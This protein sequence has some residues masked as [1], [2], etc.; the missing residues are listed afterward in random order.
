MKRKVR[1][2]KTL[3]V[4]LL[5]VALVLCA[6]R[7]WYVNATAYSFETQEYGIGEWIPLNGDFFYS[8]EENT[9]GYSVRVREA[10][11]VRYEDFMQ[12][13]GKPV[14]YLAENTQHDVVLLTV[15]FKNENN[16]DGGVFIRD[17]NLLNEAQ[18]AYFNKSEIYMKI[19]NPDLNSKADGIS[20][21]PGTEA[22]L[23]MVYP[24]SGRADGVTYLEEQAGKEQ[25]V[26]YLNVSLYPVKKCVHTG[27]TRWGFAHAA[28]INEEDR[29]KRFQM[30]FVLFFVLQNHFFTICAASRAS[31]SMA[32]KSPA[33]RSPPGTI[34][35]PPQHSTFGS[36]RYSA[37]FCALIPPVGMNFMLP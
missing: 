34:Q 23:Y 28:P 5:S 36:A 24:T 16:T 13:F 33:S 18:S 35:L 9:N 31:A 20:V 27:A 14:D 30:R 6:W 25:I 1:V 12:R 4:I 3:S 19:A 10:E 17:F 15:D 22:S 21:M 11:V 7:I 26:M 2:S 37:A 29:T 32:S 8:K